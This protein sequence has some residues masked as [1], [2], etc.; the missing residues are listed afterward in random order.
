MVGSM[1]A[2]IKTATE[3]FYVVPGNYNAVIFPKRPFKGLSF[4]GSSN[5]LV[6]DCNNNVFHYSYCQ[7]TKKTIFEFYFN[8]LPC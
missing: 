2:I 4:V 1:R 8:V 6:I 3:K 5:K 7:L